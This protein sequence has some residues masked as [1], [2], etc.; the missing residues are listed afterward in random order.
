MKFVENDPAVPNYSEF[1][2]PKREYYHK[3]EITNYE[4]N[5]VCLL[6][7]QLNMTNSHEILSFILNHGLLQTYEDQKLQ[8]FYNEAK[9]I[10]L[11]FIEDVRSLDFS[12]VE[13]ALA[14]IKLAAQITCNKFENKV[15]ETIK[16]LY[17]FQPENFMNA[18]VTIKTYAIY[19]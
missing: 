3:T 1:L 7:Y 6:N 13:V 8:N 10:L 15:M 18:Y 17:G 11:F 4:K 19:F 5:C 14:S 16:K 2:N 12:Q 9:N